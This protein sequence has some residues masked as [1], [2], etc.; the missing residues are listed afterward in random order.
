MIVIYMPEKH[1][2]IRGQFEILHQSYIADL[3][4]KILQAREI[5]ELLS[6]EGWDSDSWDSLYR[7]IHSLAGS[8]AIYGFPM[9]SAAALALDIQLKPIIRDARAPGESQ[10]KELTALLDRVALA[11]QVAQPSSTTLDPN[12]AACA[13]APEASAPGVD[14]PPAPVIDPASAPLVNQPPI[15]Q[16]DRDMEGDA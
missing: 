10:K 3:P 11:A 7:L 9:V 1:A 12:D 6:D 4:V 14:Q 13:A 15:D 8:G 2:A 16:Q 5:W